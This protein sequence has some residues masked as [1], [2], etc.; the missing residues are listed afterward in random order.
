MLARGATVIDLDTSFDWRV[1]TFAIGITLLTG[2]AAGIGPALRGTRVSLAESLKSQ[3]RT[4]GAEGGRRGV[5][6][7]KGLVAAQIAF[8]LLPLV[9]AALFTR[10]MQSLLRIDVGFDREQILVARI[11][12]RSTGYSASQRQALYERILSRLSSVPGVTSASISMN[13]PLGTSQRTSSLGDL[14]TNEGVVTDMY[15]ETVGLEILKGRGFGPE[16]RA[17]GANTSVINESMARRFFP[18]GG[19]IGK[20]WDYA[21]NFT[22]ISARIVGIVKD[23]KYVDVRG[24]APNMIYRLSAGW[25]DDVLSNFEVRTSIPPA[26]LASTIKK[27][28]AEGEPGLPVFDIVPLDERLNRGL[29]SDRLVANLTA[30]F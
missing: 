4:V 18:N 12:L 2:L 20:R 13:G 10:S 16:D 11:D 29:S 26:Q 21:D 14:I 1:M 8:C 5:L 25:R 9:I 23:A 28:L 27:V 19:A 17:P 30:A 3:G 15:F 22:G 7:G 6:I 24:A